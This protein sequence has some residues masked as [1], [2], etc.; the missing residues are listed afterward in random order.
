MITLRDIFKHLAINFGIVIGVVM[1]GR[2]FSPRLAYES[3]LILKM[4]IG[5]K[6]AVIGTGMLL[7]GFVN[8]RCDFM[9]WII[10]IAVPVAI[11]ILG[12]ALSLWGFFAA[13]FAVGVFFIIAAWLAS[14]VIP[15]PYLAIIGIILALIGWSLKPTTL[16]AP[17]KEPEPEF[18]FM[19]DPA[20]VGA[21]RAKAERA[22]RPDL[23]EINQGRGPQ[24]ERYV[25]PDNPHPLEEGLS[26]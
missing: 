22:K 19:T 26:R 23:Y 7:A 10:G 6:I 21:D 4:D 9:C 1:L 18:T 14:G 11:I 16:P 2:F 13:V 15:L 5:S 25:D 24:S 20:M 8:L 12:I 3:S 17:V